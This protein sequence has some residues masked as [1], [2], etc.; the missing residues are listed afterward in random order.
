M[1]EEWKDIKGYEGKYMVSNLG[2]VKSLKDSHGNDRDKILKLIKHKSG[3]LQVV[4][5]LNSKCKIFKVHRLVAKSYIPNPNNLPVINH[6]DEN[7]LNNSAQNLE[8]CSAKY[9]TR[10]SQA[11][12][13]G[14]YKNGNLIKVY[15]AIID[16]GLDGFKHSNVSS[17]CK[18]KLNTH[19]GYQWKY[20]E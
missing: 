3:Y 20:V 18:G 19:H 16:V 2:R 4:L 9:N 13:V 5:S 11:K 1:I 15:N 7:K 17:C 6:K 8:W 10:Y 14:C 12:K